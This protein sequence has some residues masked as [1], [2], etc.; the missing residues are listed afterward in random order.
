MSPFTLDSLKLKIFTALFITAVGTETVYY[1]YKRLRKHPK[2]RIQNE[3]LFFPD[4]GIACSAYFDQKS[5]CNMP[6]CSYTHEITNLRRVIERLRTS[7]K[8]LDVCIF[9][10]T[11]YEIGQEIVNLKRKGVKIRIIVDY[12]MANS[13]GSQIELFRKHGIPVRTKNVSQLMHHKFAIIDEEFLIC[14][15]FNWTMQ[16]V[17]SNWENVILTSEPELVQPFAT[18]FQDLWNEFSNSRN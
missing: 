8:S 13:S 7:K 18:H 16:A 15:S 6:N 12:E 3:V 11:C 14:G 1:F 4:K 2:K 5:G 17:T 10:L 9:I